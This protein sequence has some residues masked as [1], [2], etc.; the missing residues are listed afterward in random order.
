[1]GLAVEWIGLAYILVY[2]LLVVFLQLCRR[3][4][5]PTAR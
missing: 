4:E 1:M 2:V 5:P 3:E